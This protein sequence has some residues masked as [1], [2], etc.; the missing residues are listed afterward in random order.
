MIERG[1]CLTCDSISRCRL[2]SVEK[3]LNGFT[4]ALFTPTKEEVYAARWSLMQQYGETFAVQAI[5]AL[6]GED[7]DGR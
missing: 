3:V 6:K 2:T 7:A 1:D 5:L 4:C